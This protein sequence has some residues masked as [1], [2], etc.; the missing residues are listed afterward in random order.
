MPEIPPLPPGFTLDSPQGDIPP[1][2]EGFTLDTPPRNRAAELLSLDRPLT[3]AERA[4][5]AALEE[6]YGMRLVPRRGQWG[7][8]FRHALGRAGRIAIEGLSSLPN[9]AADAGIAARNL[10]T[11]ENNP[12]LSQLQSQSLDQLGLPR[13]QGGLE[14]AVDFAGQVV[15]GSKI[16]SPSARVQAPSGFTA[17]P[18]T[19]QQQIAR[20]VIAAG[21]KHGVP[22]FFDDVTN[23]A[24][25]R[26]AGT[27]AESLPGPFGTG[28]GREL[29]GRAAQ[30][31]ATRVVDDLT[32]SVGDDV[33]VLVQKGLQRKLAQFKQSANRLYT[34]AAQ[35]LD[36][37]G[38]VPRNKFDKVIEAE[39]SRQ[40]KL[41]TLAS[42]EVKSLLEKYQNAPKG[43]FSLMRELRS[44]LGEEI[45]DFYTGKNAAVGDRG[46]KALRAMQEAL[47]QDLAEFAKQSGTKGYQAWR[48][49]DGFYKANI[50]PFKEAGFR[51]LVKTAEPEKAWRYLLS[52][53]SLKSRA[54]RMYNS[55]DEPGRS[56]V[57]YGMVKDALDNATNPNGTFSPAKF[58]KYL[59]DHEE[60]VNAFFK[61]RDLT[62][63]R[64]FQN[65]MRHVERA[66]Q[67]AEN[68]PTG[69]RLIPYLLGGAAVVEPSAAA[70]IGAAGLT[71]RTLF[72]TT[73]GR[74]LLLGMGKV[75]PGSPQA[76]AISDR[77]ARFLA[78]SAAVAGSA[79][80]RSDQEQM[81]TGGGGR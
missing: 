19:P 32:P 53:G 47:E 60:A 16:P 74:N 80:A 71:V 44:Q 48:A 46:V 70:S 24:V 66:G 72:Q 45:S 49:A 9:I 73:K 79:S 64:G 10:I 3:D 31:A 30:T 57:R 62:E 52:Q 7:S 56:A 11:G 27:A 54:A 68:P 18:P 34:R 50:V 75:K 40:D 36:P 20:D 69:N 23:S 21:E 42:S 51:D 25:A 67:F 14:K 61:G 29:Q 6:Q 38:N 33:P 12:G 39:M 17:R 43:N 22:V 4:E 1:L 13:A 58:A 2:P 76:Q 59:E 78:Q 81:T 41:G 65:L 35:Q 55:L 8:E 26:K 77:I 5:Y 63:I 28:A 37:L 15:V